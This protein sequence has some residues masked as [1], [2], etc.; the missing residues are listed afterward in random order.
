MN[1]DDIS[2]IYQHIATVPEIY[3]TEQPSVNRMNA[4]T[5]S[6]QRKKI[7]QQQGPPLS[8]DNKNQVLCMSGGERAPE[9]F[10]LR[11][12]TTQVCLHCESSPLKTKAATPWKQAY[13][14][15]SA[16]QPSSQVTCMKPTVGREENPHNCLRKVPQEKRAV[17]EWKPNSQTCRVG[18]GLDT[19][20]LTTG[21][22]QSQ[23]VTRWHLNVAP[24]PSPRMLRERSQKAG[25]CI[26]CKPTVRSI[27]KMLPVSHQD[28]N[29]SLKSN[30]NHN[31][32]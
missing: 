25:C 29:I 12:V 24:L 19:A 2:V 3:S 31:M 15:G 1:D 5:S 7:I 10:N 30:A 18:G 9:A 8:A 6:L 27:V 23:H 11:A 28:D 22:V 21:Y 14:G 20:G 16:V 17:G 26:C 4:S 13:G 32:K